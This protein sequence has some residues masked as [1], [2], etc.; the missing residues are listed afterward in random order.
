MI[1]DLCTFL[2]GDGRDHGLEESIFEGRSGNYQKEGDTHH[3]PS[4]NFIT[5]REGRG[6]PAAL[7]HNSTI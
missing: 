6:I 5:K 4:L 1:P 3:T 2:V 7:Y